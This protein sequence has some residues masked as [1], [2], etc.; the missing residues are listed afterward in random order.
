MVSRGRFNVAG[1]G[2][3]AVSMS[4]YGPVNHTEYVDTK[5]ENLWLGRPILGD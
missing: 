4:R 3:D 5:Q 1:G 2:P